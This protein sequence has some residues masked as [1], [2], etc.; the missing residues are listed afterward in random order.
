MRRRALL[1]GLAATLAAGQAG[2]AAAH[3]LVRQWEVYRAK[4]LV[5]GCD[6]GD[7][8]AYRTAKAVERA[9]AEDLPAASARV[10]RAPHPE[11][12]AS[13]MA[14][15]QL[16]LAL[17]APATAQA[18]AAG[19]GVFAPYGPQ[20]LSTL[21]LMPT[22]HALLAH[23]RFPDRHATVV[24]RALGTGPLADPASLAT[25]PPCPWRPEALAALR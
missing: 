16:D 25:V 8:L 11:R 19:S 15:A 4:H 17:L 14:T 24:A 2:P 20:A 21:F 13:L 6:R 18:M 9:L 22:G 10:A 5:I 23:P 1:A 12:L 7:P 3:T